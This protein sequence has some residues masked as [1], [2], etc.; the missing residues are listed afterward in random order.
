MIQS[1]IMALVLVVG[2]GYA[3]AWTGPTAPPPGANVAAPLNVSA[4]D[5]YKAGALSLGTSIIA[6][7]LNASTSLRTLSGKAAFGTSAPIPTNLRALFSGN[8]GASK[9]CN[10]AGT[11]CRS[12]EEILTFIN[13]N[14]YGQLPPPAF[15]SGWVAYTNGVTTSV[16]HNL[17][18]ENYIVYLE[19]KSTGA[20]GVN[21]TYSTGEL[22]GGGAGLGFYW[23][24]KTAN[25]IGIRR[26]S[27]S[28]GHA[29]IRVRLWKY[30]GG[31][32][33]N[34]SLTAECYSNCD[35]LGGDSSFSRQENGREVLYISHDASVASVRF[36]WVLNDLPAPGSCTRTVSTNPAGKLLH[37]G[38]NSWDGDTMTTSASNAAQVTVKSV[39]D[40]TQYGGPA[41]Y[42]FR[43]SCS[44]GYSAEVDVKNYF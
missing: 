32:N 3:A 9:Y 24:Q 35:S 22:D 8:V 5:Q 2:V 10:E 18:T 38:T 28:A 17:G 27:N 7:S 40:T 23:E 37:T 43:L 12:I 30:L 1:V 14:Y 42:T 26:Q 41:I 15:D 11:V 34:V 19:A 31:T 16:T 25:S 6:G 39:T 4:I 44:G 13:N 36:N 29:N 21:S 20:S 33:Q